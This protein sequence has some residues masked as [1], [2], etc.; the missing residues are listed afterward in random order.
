LVVTGFVA[1]QLRSI[2][3]TL[4][5]EGCLIRYTFRDRECAD[6]NPSRSTGYAICP[7][8]LPLNWL[9][10]LL[11]GRSCIRP[12]RIIHSTPKPATM[13]PLHHHLRGHCTGPNPLFLPPRARGVGV[14]LPDALRAVAQRCRFPPP[15][16]RANQA[17]P[18]QTLQGTQT[19]CWPDP[20]TTVRPV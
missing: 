17:I 6:D 10:V 16:D 5:N 9:R 3:F 4:S 7:A 15:A 12:L 18:T 13:S 19:V 1:L 8:D 11:I 20:A 14:R 2:S